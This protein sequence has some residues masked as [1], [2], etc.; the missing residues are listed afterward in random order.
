MADFR[1][2]NLDSASESMELP[3]VV[4]KAVDLGETTVARAVFQP[5][6]RWSTHMQPLVGGDWCQ[7]RH[8]GIILSGAL[9]LTFAD[10]TELVLSKNDVYDVPPG[11]DGYVVGDE[12]LEMVE[13]SGHRTYVRNLAGAT[14][15]ILT[16]LL[17]TDVVGSTELV[18]RIGDQAWRDLSVDLFRQAR[19]ALEK[20]S[21]REVDVAG[22][23]MLAL[24]NG[25]ALAL[26][27]ANA[28]KAIAERLDM[29]I[30]AGV[31]VGE[32]ELVGTAVRGIAVHLA[33]RV[34][35]A[36]EPDQVLVSETA[37]VLAAGSGFDFVD[38]GL[39]TLKGLEGS[40]RL[41]EVDQ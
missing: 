21:G 14:E 7:A 31:H 30:R 5:G 13:W 20:F 35:A 24:F 3:L 18:G 10:G 28:I 4:S 27:C 11:H 41:Y 38:K 9:G 8:V 33:A 34:L 12:P 17:F 37:R 40:H 36:A 19:G 1:R 6:W 26:R 15:R 22:D 29:Q 2:T 32:V 23:G 25:P 39:H 16:T